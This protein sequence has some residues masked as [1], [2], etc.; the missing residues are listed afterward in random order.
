MSKLITFQMPPEIGWCDSVLATKLLPIHFG[1]IT[2][3]KRKWSDVENARTLKLSSIVSSP[4][5]LLHVLRQVISLSTLFCALSIHSQTVLTVTNYGAVG[6]AVQFFVNTASNSVVVTTTSLFSSADIG[7]AIEVF[8]VGIQTSGIDSFGHT[9]NG[10]QDMVATI[11]NVVRGTNV[12]LSRIAQRTLANAF[13]TCGHNNSDAFQNAINACSG[14]NAMLRI[15]AGKYLLL[16][17]YSAA[18]YGY[19]GLIIRRGGIH[20]IGEGTNA[21]T[22][23]G[24]GAWAMQSGYPTRGFLVMI[25][26]PI[27][28][29]YPFSIEN[30]TLDGGVQ[31]GNIPIHGISANPVDGLGWDVSHDAIVVR[32]AGSTFTRQ[33][34]TNVL[35]THWRGEMV[36]SNDGSTNGNLGIYNCAF[37][38]GDATALNYYASLNVSNCLFNNLFQ[39]AEYYQAYS[40]NVS[41][42][43][44][45]IVTNITGNGFA[46]NG[47]KGINPSFILRNNTFYFPGNGYNGIETTPADNVFIISNQFFFNLVGG[48]AIAL[49]A[50]GAQGTF[51]NSN[52]VVAGNSFVEPS[53][54][55]VN[56]GGA[57]DATGPNR[58]ESVQVYGNK[59]TRH[60]GGTAALQTYGW[61]TNIHFFNNDFHSDVSNTPCISWSSGTSGAQYASV[62][63]NNLCYSP[64]YDLVG[65]TNFISYAKG[66]KFEVLYPF[67]AGTVYA[68]VDTNAS[69]MPEGAQI[70]IY[71]KNTSLVSVPLYLDSGLKM[72]P[73]MVPS[74]QAV[75]VYWKGSVW[76]TNRTPD[77]PGGMFPPTGLHLQY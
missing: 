41:I 43:Q 74:G 20:L 70:L 11:T 18:A 35:F 46:L 64:I 23:L 53:A 61:T 65:K 67:H 45:N 40:T 39:I 9:T 59:L 60:F 52:I 51:D 12:Y 36:K 17:S 76:T 7:K 47:G 29:D 6:D 1:M 56:E 30:L 10:N 57:I 71:N 26:P 16:S 4:R 44:N 55:I 5:L 33:T 15:P 38:D 37:T 8:G 32:G 19:V 31:Y 34:W 69:Q 3:M 66:A 24:Q 54:I 48:N 27:T 75:T 72:G 28:N 73:V 58:V 2:L 49:G 62:D 50:M 42:F 68:L 25:I 63:L 77:V 21:T 14:T 13:A 22:L